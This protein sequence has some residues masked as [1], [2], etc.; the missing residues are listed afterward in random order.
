MKRMKSWVMH[1]IIATAIIMIF[2]GCDIL[3]SLL[4]PSPGETNE[5]EVQAV[6]EK[7][8]E[9]EI[10]RF[11]ILRVQGPSERIED[12][13]SVF[14]WVCEDPE[15]VIANYQYRKDGGAWTDLGMITDYT[16]ASYSRGP[17]VFE[18]RAQDSEG[19]YSHVLVWR[20]TYGVKFPVVVTSAGQSSGRAIWD[21]LAR[22]TQLDYIRDDTILAER[23]A[24]E[25][26]GTLIILVGVSLKGLGAKELTFEQ[27]KQRVKSLLDKAEAI[28]ADVI[29]VHIEGKAVRGRNGDELIEIVLPR[30]TAVWIIEESDFDGLF[31][32]LCK[33][34]SIR[35][36]TIK[37]VD[38]LVEVIMDHFGL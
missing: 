2:S 8:T 9:D 6:E 29:L 3:Q 13:D 23:L 7:M 24:E 10:G 21:F 31:S 25:N 20:F 17:H 27:E 22:K 12:I 18:V 16:W 19:Y 1:V 15:K 32:R 5:K 33:K 38:A 28:G 26:T 30:S 35:L 11:A 34:Y 14:S 37:K 4:A 36:L